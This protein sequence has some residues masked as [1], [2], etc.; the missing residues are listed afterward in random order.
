[1][2]HN[3]QNWLNDW[4][5]NHST[6]HKLG[7]FARNVL[8]HTQVVYISSHTM[9][10]LAVSWQSHIQSECACWG[11]LAVCSSYHIDRISGS[12]L[13][14]G[15]M[16]DVMG[17]LESHR[18]AHII[19]GKIHVTSFWLKIQ[20]WIYTLYIRMETQYK[21]Y[22][23][24][25]IS[26]KYLTFTMVRQTTCFYGFCSSQWEQGKTDFHNPLYFKNCRGSFNS[27]EMPESPSSTGNWQDRHGSKAT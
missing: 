19:P 25:E 8:S 1:M 24:S 6:R 3:I 22:H 21:L 12:V 13:P 20:S 14:Q 26:V 27:L 11:C 17:L 18:A 16:Y 7:V 15:P 5:F 9:D 10:T 23:L 2:L 4:H